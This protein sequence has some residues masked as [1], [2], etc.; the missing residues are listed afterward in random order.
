MGI[1]SG[2]GDRVGDAF[3]RASASLGGD[4]YSDM[5]DDELLEVAMR[6]DPEFAARWSKK[7][8]AKANAEKL[9][10]TTGGI[11]GTLS[12]PEITQRMMPDPL[13]GPIAPE[14]T[15]GVAP[16]ST[17][18]LGETKS[19][20]ADKLIQAE[21]KG[22]G[23]LNFYQQ[24]GNMEKV[25]KLQMINKLIQSGVP[26]AQ[27]VGLA[28]L[29]SIYTDAMKAPAAPPGPQAVTT[30]DAGNRWY[31]VSDGKGGFNNIK[32]GGQSIYKKPTEGSGQQGQFKDIKQQYDVESSM[33]KNYVAQSKDA[34]KTIKTFENSAPA[35]S[36]AIQRDAQGNIT[37]YDF[38]K[39]SG[40]EQAMLIRNA[41]IMSEPNSAVNSGE[42]DMLK[43]TLSLLGITEQKLK[44][45]AEGNTTLTTEQVGN[46]F[47][48]MLGIRAVAK[49]S[50]DNTREYFG[51]RRDA[52]GF[53]PGSVM[54]AMPTMSDLGT[55]DAYMN[56]VM[57][58]ET[59]TAAV[60]S[61]VQQMESGQPTLEQLKAERNRRRGQ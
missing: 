15:E 25:H 31:A 11:M 39:L 46:L 37:G 2:I 42:V 51:N 58:P 4:P 29:N 22:E 8:A 26:A 53:E 7:Q 60:A 48:M 20:Y 50:L 17:G 49:G 16:E 5:S 36:K 12:T 3:N 27:E 28:N 18:L 1:L 38:S 23:L 61:Q 32:M 54:K 59:N 13:M 47:E 19:G 56:F 43:D 45:I 6:N 52:Y 21:Q 34:L 10:Q 14:G 9:A 55:R 33:N 57:Q 30:D 40:V 41:M 44:S 24:Q 35:L